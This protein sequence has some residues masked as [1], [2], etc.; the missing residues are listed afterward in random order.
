M[1]NLLECV[2]A[3]ELVRII[4]VYIAGEASREPIGMQIEFHG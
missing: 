2:V 1:R 4:E 3:G